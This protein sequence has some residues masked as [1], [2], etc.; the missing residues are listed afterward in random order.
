VTFPV[1]VPLG[2]LRLDPHAVF[3]GL[4]YFAAFRLYLVQRRRLG[5]AI[6]N[7]SRWSV[8]AAAA[9]GAA[10]GS[11]LFYWFEDPSATWVHRGDVW[12]LLGGKT[13]VGGLVGGLLAVE[14][15]KRWLGIRTS[16]GDLF[17]VP[18][19]IGIA[20]G[21]IG[22]FLAG[23]PDGTFGTPSSLPWAVDFGDGIRRHPTQLYEVIVLVALGAVCRRVQR[24]PHQSGDVFKIFMVGYMA[25]R[26][27]VDTIKPEV[28]IALGL[29]ALQWTAIGVLVYY[30]PDVARWI[31]W[32]RA[33]ST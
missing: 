10:L 31:G 14:L 22:C 25:C 20:I 21:R 28:R 19:A 2:P 3:E 15:A 8:L 7:H 27:A 23:L 29:S 11:R 16:T 9:V 32:G 1:Y 33:Q 6:D 12:F 17:A 30:A 13:V 26:L 4:A 24:Q 5:D 18:L